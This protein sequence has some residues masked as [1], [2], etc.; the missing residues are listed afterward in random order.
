V[1]NKIN[2]I[3]EK[4]KEKNSESSSM[5]DKIVE[6]ANWF[7]DNYKEIANEYNY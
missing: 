2:K 5:N 6:L 1:E 4:I 7:N 3:I